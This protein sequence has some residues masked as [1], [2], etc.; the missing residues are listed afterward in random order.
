MAQ[1]LGAP[2]KYGSQEIA[3]EFRLMLLLVMVAIALFAVMSGIQAGLS[4]PVLGLSPW[5]SSAL[6]VAFVLA[7]VL[8]RRVNG[9]RIRG[10]GLGLNGGV[11]RSNGR[12]P[13]GSVSRGSSRLLTPSA[14][15]MH[16]PVAA[17]QK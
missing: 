11:Q 16:Q 2:R 17:R 6:S 10:Q 4:L 1:V 5:H 3:R 14:P 9:T 7:I 12:G 8:I 13:C 15:R